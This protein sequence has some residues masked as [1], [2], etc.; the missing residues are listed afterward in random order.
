MD[1]RVFI[2]YNI[3]FTINYRHTHTQR[4]N[5]S[6]LIGL[7]FMWV[8]AIRVCMMTLLY[9]TFISLEANEIR[10]QRYTHIVTTQV[11]CSLSP[12]QTITSVLKCI[13]VCIFARFKLSS[14]LMR[15]LVVPF[16][17]FL[18]SRKIDIVAHI[19]N[20]IFARWILEIAKHIF[21]SFKNIKFYLFRQ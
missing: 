1:W 16:V 6:T 21:L 5:I 17:F 12:V 19:I 2:L 4:T 14:K 7:I 9:Y 11:T 10:T 8:V 20:A 13:R 3:N 15:T 18:S